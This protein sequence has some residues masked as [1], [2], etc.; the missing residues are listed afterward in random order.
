MCNKSCKRDSDDGL[1]EFRGML[2]GLGV[3]ALFWAAVYV[4]SKYLAVFL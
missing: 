1:A 2:C 3:C 4:W